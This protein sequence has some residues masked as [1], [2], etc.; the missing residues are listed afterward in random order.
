MSTVL[1]P[2]DSIDKSSGDR[3]TNLQLPPQ[4]PRGQRK[5]FARAL[6]ALSSVCGGSSS[7]ALRVRSGQANYRTDFRSRSGT[8]G[9]VE[10]HAVVP[11]WVDGVDKVADERVEALYWSAWHATSISFSQ[12]FG[13]S[14][15]TLTLSTDA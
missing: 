4:N 14:G 8:G 10:F 3:P 15:I 12:R 7:S 9:S 11:L 2:R 6:G 5:G 13:W 1:T